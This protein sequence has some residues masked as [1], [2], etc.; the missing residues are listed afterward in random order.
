MH[1]HFNDS[2][3]PTPQ[4]LITKMVSKIQHD[5]S[6]ILEP[7]A[8]MGHIVE[9]LT[10]DYRHK[11]NDIS[12]IES[13]DNL[14]ATLR[15][16]S[17]KVIDSDFLTFSGPDKFDLIIANPPFSEGDK[18]L[19]KAIDIM[20]R[21]EIIFLLNAETLKNPHTNTRKALVTKLDDL[22][23]DIEYI[24]DGFRDAERQTNVEVALIYINIERTV[25]D[26]LFEGANDKTETVN[27]RVRQKGEISTGKTVFELVA[28]YNNTVKLCTDTIINY[29][30]NYK[31]VGEFVAL[32]HKPDKYHHNDEDLTGIM[33]TQLNNM[34]TSVRVK[35]WRET[36]N[37][38]AVEK[39]M[40]Q[41]RMDEFETAL[42]AN[43]NMDFTE[44]NIRTFIINLIGGYEKTLTDAVLEI[45]DMF[46]VK[47]A[48]SGG[49]HEKNIHYF[50]G[51]KTNKSFK[52]GNKV[53]IPIYGGYSDGPFVGY[54]GEWKLDYSAARV[55]NDIDIV[56][57][58]F[59]GMN[60]YLSIS[61]ALEQAYKQ[62][63]SRS[64]DSQYFT[65]T[66]YKKGTI[67]LTFKDDDILRRFNVAACRG[68]QWLP[69]DYGAKKYDVLLVEDKHVVDA[70]EGETSYAKNHK[71]PI[72]SINNSQL[73][74]V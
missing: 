23:A 68:K 6:K 29:Y 35:F 16:K 39:R 25:E 1:E 2:F 65:I 71:K 15:G 46:T 44:H 3:F 72:F 24:Q 66:T 43:C 52:V 22:N 67:H 58:Y 56:M 62:G 40:T 47:H 27:E 36:L 61:E 38:D 41:K 51:W 17:I 69:E 42:T 74:L 31:K 37:I 12:A 21:G 26:D 48:W 8:G 30:R 55:L 14:R 50:N 4:R 28:D 49:V 33:Q 7:S 32:N 9:Y 70:F 20:Y 18:H 63:E 64:I 10:D 54:S 60:S 5:P 34:L 19:L 13:D 59:D 45:F 53:I 11:N 73:K 57:N